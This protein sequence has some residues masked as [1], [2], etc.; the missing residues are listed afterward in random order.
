MVIRYYT[1]LEKRLR[2]PHNYKVCCQCY[3]IARSNPSPSSPL[4]THIHHTAHMT[5]Q[6]SCFVYFTYIQLSI[7]QFYFLTANELKIYVASQL[8]TTTYTTHLS[9]LA[10]SLQW[11]LIARYLASQLLTTLVIWLYQKLLAV[12]F[13]LWS[14]ALPVCIF[15]HC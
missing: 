9:L 1:L 13:T 5:P 3:S 10:I 7:I 2:Q 4:P 11:L 6:H 12:S 15:Q 8:S 14:L